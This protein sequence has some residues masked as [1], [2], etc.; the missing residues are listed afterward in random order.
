MADNGCELMGEIHYGLELSYEEVGE[1]EPLLQERLES[2]LAKL[3]PEAFDVRASG[4]E[5]VFV[6]SLTLCKPDDLR[7]MCR[8]LGSLLGPGAKGRL[9]YVE[10]GFGQVMAWVF[11]PLGCQEFE[12]FGQA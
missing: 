8:E 3:G 6:S 4:D 2:L 11:T 5:M 1:L 12:A 7:D 9:V 10:R